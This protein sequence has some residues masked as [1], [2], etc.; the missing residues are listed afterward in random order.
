MAFRHWIQLGLVPTSLY[1]NLV[2]PFGEQNEGWVILGEHMA[3]WLLLSARRHA[4]LAVV[5]TF[6]SRLQIK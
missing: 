6:T 3:S 2:A 5:I 1:G 4:N